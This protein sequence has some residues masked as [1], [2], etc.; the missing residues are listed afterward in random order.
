MTRTVR[1]VPTRESDCGL[2]LVA[3][4]S[5]RQSYGGTLG[6]TGKIHARRTPCVHHKG[7]S[8]PNG[9]VS[10]LR[11]V[12]ARGETAGG[13]ALSGRR[14]VPGGFF[15]KIR[16]PRAVHAPFPLLPPPL[17]LRRGGGRR[18]HGLRLLLPNR[19]RGGMRRF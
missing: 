4:P 14:A 13:Q 19:T 17:S 16:C 3:R 15:L 9:C 1:P 11:A 8:G 18:E 10:P 2:Q 12:P 5:W 7:V 6:P